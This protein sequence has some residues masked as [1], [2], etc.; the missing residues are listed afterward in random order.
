MQPEY[1]LVDSLKGGS[2]VA[3]DWQ[4]LQVFPWIPHRLHML[5]P[6]MLQS[7]ARTCAPSAG[8]QQAI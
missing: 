5:L 8:Q 7:A 1:L 4:A 3:L 2:G 6:M